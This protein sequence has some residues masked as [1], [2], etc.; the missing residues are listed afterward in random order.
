MRSFFPN[1]L[2]AN[3]PWAEHS[4]R[5]RGRCRTWVKC[6]NLL[7][8][9]GA[10]THRRVKLLGCWIFVLKCVECLEF[11]WHQRQRWFREI[12]GKTEMARRPI[13]LLWLYYSP[14]QN[15]LIFVCSL[16]STPQR[17]TEIVATEWGIRSWEFFRCRLHSNSLPLWQ[18]WAPN[19]PKKKIDCRRNSEYAGLHH[20]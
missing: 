13:A 6:T 8:P 10:E 4:R 12:F 11:D 19:K 2:R 3:C 1:A 18:V 5:K 7:W 14:T 9:C 20:K 17:Y 16:C 15:R